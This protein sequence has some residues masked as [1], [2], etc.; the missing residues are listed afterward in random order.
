MF[1]T[2]IFVSFF[3][4]HSGLL[5]IQRI[6]F[7]TEFWIVEPFSNH[8]QVFFLHDSQIHGYAF[9]QSSMLLSTSF[10][11]S[12][13]I[14]YDFALALFLNSL[15]QFL[16]SILEPPRMYAGSLACANESWVQAVS[17]R[18]CQKRSSRSVAFS[19]LVSQFCSLSFRQESPIYS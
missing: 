6:I 9:K 2:A 11:S 3:D 14:V 18:S 7:A 12:T 10:V 13:L 15:P 17:F 4:I 5:F 16:F 19:L 8:W 1:K